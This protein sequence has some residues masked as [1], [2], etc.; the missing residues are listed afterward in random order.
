[1]AEARG[2]YVSELLRQWIDMGL[3]G[4]AEAEMVA[5]APV[6]RYRMPVE[7]TERRSVNSGSVRTVVRHKTQIDVEVRHGKGSRG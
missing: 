7:T 4:H 3:Q 1:M 2:L 5:V 6:V